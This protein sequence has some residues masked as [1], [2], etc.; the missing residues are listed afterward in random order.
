MRFIDLN[1]HPFPNGF[2]IYFYASEAQTNTIFAACCDAAVRFF[3]LDWFNNYNIIRS[4]L[5]NALSYRY[6]FS[7]N[8]TEIVLYIYI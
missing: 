5:V 4:K 6:L 8:I 2:S 7:F 1:P 3:D